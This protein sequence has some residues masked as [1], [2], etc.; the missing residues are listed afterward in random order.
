VYLLSAQH[1]SVSIL[2]CTLKRAWLDLLRD[3]LEAIK[4]TD[5]PQV[6]EYGPVDL[7]SADERL[8]FVRMLCRL[9][10]HLMEEARFGQEMMEEKASDGDVD[11]D[12]KRE[13]EKG[14]G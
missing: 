8:L 13:V 11:K 9:L 3:D 10:F 2:R 6:E 12:R 1:T 7:S 14:K 4:K 5:K